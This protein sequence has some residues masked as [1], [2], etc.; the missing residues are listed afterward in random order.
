MPA[1]L[2]VMTNAVYGDY[3]NIHFAQVLYEAHIAQTKICPARKVFS[4]SAARKL[5]R[6][7]DTVDFE[8]YIKQCEGLDLI[9]D[10]CESFVSTVNYEVFI[11][12]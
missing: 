9:L 10:L 2:S 7:M 1:K 5:R 12:I 3:V 4:I 11:C 8:I 6:N